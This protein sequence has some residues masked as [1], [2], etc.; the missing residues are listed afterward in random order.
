M[1]AVFYGRNKTRAKALLE[2]ALL[3][4]VVENTTERSPEKIVPSNGL[5]TFQMSKNRLRRKSLELSLKQKQQFNSRYISLPSATYVQPRGM[6][7][8]ASEEITHENELTKIP[9]VELSFGN[10]SRFRKSTK[11]QKTNSSLSAYGASSVAGNTKESRTK[12]KRS[13]KSCP[14]LSSIIGTT[15]E[16][17]QLFHRYI[18]QNKKPG[19]LKLEYIESDLISG[20]VEFLR[21]SPTMVEVN[22]E[23][24]YYSFPQISAS[25]SVISDWLDQFS[26]PETESEFNA[27]KSSLE[28]THSHSMSLRSRSS[29]SKSRL[30]K[31]TYRCN[32]KPKYVP[33]PGMLCAAKINTKL[34]NRFKTFHLDA[35]LETVVDWLGTQLPIVVQEP[36]SGGR[37]CDSEWTI[38][39]ALGKMLKSPSH[40]GVAFFAGPVNSKL[41]YLMTIVDLCQLCALKTTDDEEIEELQSWV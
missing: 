11:L 4:E 25:D 17:F 13:S 10:F 35:K 31:P 27:L 28:P 1:S 30:Q 6:A 20:S 8:D 7:V 22:E 3:E 36:G 41:S 23:T 38:A 34:G 37:R 9:S 5:I 19:E 15:T 26:F 33:P 21:N 12:K 2:K 40:Q 32:L 14:S 18:T 39:E 29:R 16:D 24:D